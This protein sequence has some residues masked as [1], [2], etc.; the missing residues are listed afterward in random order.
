[1]VRMLKDGEVDITP[2]DSTITQ[3]RSTVIDFLPRLDLIHEKL[4]LWNPV[5]TPNSQAYIEPFTLHSWLGVVI[6]VIVVPLILRGIFKYSKDGSTKKYA[7]SDCLCFALK[8]LVLRDD[9]TNPKSG[10]TRTAYASIVFGGI[11][12]YY[13]WEAMLISYLSVKKV[14]MPFRTLEE[15]EK[16]SN[17]KLVVAKGFSQLDMFRSSNEYPYKDIWVKKMQ[18]YAQD[19]PLVYDL[20]ET[21]K[22]DPFSVVYVDAYQIDNNES[23]LS[24]DVVD[25]GVNIRTTQL[26]WSVSKNSPFYSAFSYHLA[27]LQEIG[28]VDKYSEAYKESDKMCPYYSGKPLPIKQCYTAFIVLISGICSCLIWLILEKLV[29]QNWIERFLSPKNENKDIMLL[30]TRGNLSCAPHN[31][32]K[33]FTTREIRNRLSEL[34]HSDLIE[35]VMQKERNEYVC[36]RLL[37]SKKEKE[38]LRKN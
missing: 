25:T 35:I 17:Y 28:G 10:A 37:K 8:T 2:V 33:E 3:S 5:G 21:M 1:M 11:M 13:L 14:Y 7:I 9:G 34:S 23:Y 20:V 38:T 18:P 36:K 26:A 31:P 6:F 4:F 27:K 12:I 29:P 24:C 19:F 16:T 30:N 15:L 22:N 32:H